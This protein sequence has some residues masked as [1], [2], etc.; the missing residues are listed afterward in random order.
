MSE[1]RTRFAP[2]PTGHLHVGGARTAL[3]NYLYARRHG[4]SFFVRIE[5]TDRER[6]APEFVD[7]II[8]GLAWLGLDYDGELCFQSRRTATYTSAL[9]R[10]LEAGHCYY[11]FCRAEE[12]ETK[13]RG[14]MER[15]GRPVYDRSCR[16]LG[17][18]PRAGERPAVRFRSP[19]EGK[20][21]VDDMVR[22]EV[23][24]ENAE[25]D[26][27][28][29]ARSDGSPTYQL[30]VV[31][32]DMDM[33]ITHV[34]RGEDHLTN[35]PKQINVFRALG[36]EPPRYGHMPLIV[37]ADRSR[38]SKRHGA[39][40]I[41]AY[42]DQGFLPEAALNYLARLGW[43]RG[44]QEIFSREEL[45]RYFDIEGVG[46]AAAAFDVEKFT[47]VN[48]QHL[49]SIPDEEL[50]A[51]VLPFL[52]RNGGWVEEN[53]TLVAAVGLLKERAHTLVDLAQQSRVFLVDELCYD[54]KATEKFLTD[55]N[56][57]FLE[58]LEQALVRVE[59]WG[60]EEIEA[61]FA[62]LLEQ[63]GVKLGKL[64][65]PAR[66]AL[67]GGTRSPGIYEVCEVLGKERTLKRLSSARRKF[68]SGEL[69]RDDAGD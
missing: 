39:T 14:A 69:Q 26:D 38:L 54:T 60:A 52:E 65:Q 11:C 57:A 12:L 10:L 58:K 41:Q 45:V 44:D 22:G 66:V 64:A 34:F 42:R 63:L 67:T 19:L 13:R 29:V 37:G 6:S 5:D 40:S 53:A 17:R 48:Q 18:R 31:V 20:T 47:W 62:V 21:V 27:F 15:G 43:S 3:F 16:D 28:I 9:E 2:S 8:D 1:V 55:E 24:F 49:K 25:L 56:L 46:K 50:A 32:D 33:A 68:G 61:A 35:T 4:G 23:V 7:A 59:C 36:G 51:M 30:V